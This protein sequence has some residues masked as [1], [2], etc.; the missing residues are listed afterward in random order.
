[1]TALLSNVTIA[2]SSQIAITFDDAPTPAE[3]SA[4]GLQRTQRLLDQLRRAGVD[5]AL[6]FV[7]TKHI[8]SESI[9]RLHR[10]SNAG[11]IL[12]N[13]SHDHQSANELPV[14]KVLLDA[15]EDS[16]SFRS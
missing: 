16:H 13:H 3:S 12:G 2:R 1:M 11:H 7:T 9:E 4:A 8:N 5:Q 15:F 6:F 10:Y 14:N